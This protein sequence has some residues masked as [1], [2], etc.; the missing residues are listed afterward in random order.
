M[1][2]GRKKQIKDRKTST[3]LAFIWG[4]KKE[5]EEREKAANGGKRKEGKKTKGWNVFTCDKTQ[6]EENPLRS[7]MYIKC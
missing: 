4:Q 6:T 1:F 2:I 5:K 7:P 3:L